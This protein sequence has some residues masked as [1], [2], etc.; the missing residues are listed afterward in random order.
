MISRIE[1]YI[2]TDNAT[3]WS[4]PFILQAGLAFAVDK[5]GEMLLLMMVMR[6]RMRVRKW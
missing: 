5:D 1:H 4:G 2:Y 3:M 6:M